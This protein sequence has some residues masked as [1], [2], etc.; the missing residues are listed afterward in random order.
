MTQ[1]LDKA[2]W[3]DAA[4][5]GASTPNALLIDRVH[6]LRISATSYGNRQMCLMGKQ[7]FPRTKPKQAKVV[8]GFQTGDMVKAIVTKGVKVGT[9]VGRVAVRATGW[10]NVTTKAHRTV[11]GISYRACTLLH[12][13]DGY[14]YS[15]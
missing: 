9:Y 13:T 2:H 11:E 4:C 5:V 3:I 14:S 15:F 7:G 12:S 6:P 10:F 8:N 1:G